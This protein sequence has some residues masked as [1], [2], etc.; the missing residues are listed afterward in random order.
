MFHRLLWKLSF[1]HGCNYTINFYEGPLMKTKVIP[2]ISDK[3]IFL[4]EA[5]NNHIVESNNHGSLLEKC[6]FLPRILRQLAHLSGMILIEISS[7]PKSLFCCL[8]KWST[9][10]WGNRDTRSR[11]RDWIH[12]K[13]TCF[14]FFQVLIDLTKLQHNLWSTHWYLAPLKVCYTFIFRTWLNVNVK[15]CIAL[16]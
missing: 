2:Q 15:S 13:F 11:S 9:S 12:Y 1:S 16:A 4:E 6:L 3:L 14:Q 7:N 10:Q 8:G 5:P